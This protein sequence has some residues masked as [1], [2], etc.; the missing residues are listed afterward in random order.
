MRA[1]HG[2]QSASRAWQTA[3]RHCP[4]RRPGIGSHAALK[5]ST[6]PAR[7]SIAASRASKAASSAERRAAAAG[8]PQRTTTDTRSSR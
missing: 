5:A 1:Q 8:V 6:T 3:S 2:A 7:P 4:A